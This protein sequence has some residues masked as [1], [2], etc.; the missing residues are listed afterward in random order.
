MVTGRNKIHMKDNVVAMGLAS[1]FI[2][3]L[4]STGL[5]LVTGSLDKL[6]NYI[7]NKINEDEYNCLVNDQFD[8]L[9]DFIVAHY[10]FSK[11]SNLYW[12]HYKTVPIEKKPIPIFPN[13][14]WDT[15]LSAFLP[16][17]KRPK[18]PLD[19]KELINIHKGT[20]Y[21]KWIQDET[22]FT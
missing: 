11:R 18:E 21:H 8:T 10:K 13:S 16:E 2:E 20:L 4:E 9:T 12:D 1:N 19:P 6:C 5:F 22:N 17:V 15:I 14:G 3:P 7:D